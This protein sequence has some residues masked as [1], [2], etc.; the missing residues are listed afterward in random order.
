MVW[1][2][3]NHVLRA[4]TTHSPLQG[5]PASASGG[6]DEPAAFSMLAAAPTEA[7]QTDS[8]LPL[9]VACHKCK[10]QPDQ[11][12]CCHAILASGNGRPDWFGAQHPE[13]TQFKTSPFLFFLYQL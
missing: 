3:G 9:P 11:R 7:F 6:S 1:L 10:M 2:E 12:A 13:D 8:L 4:L 5:I